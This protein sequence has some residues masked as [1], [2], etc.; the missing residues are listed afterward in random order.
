[1]I[2]PGGLGIDTT[3]TLTPISSQ[4]PATPFPIGWT[5]IKAVDI[6]APGDFDPP[7]EITLIDDKRSAVNQQAVVA[8]FDATAMA[9]IAVAA[10]D[11]PPSGEVNVQGI[12]E[13]GQYALL[14]P[15]GGDGAPVAPIPGEPLTSGSELSLPAEAQAVGVVI[16]SVG[17]SDDPTP[18]KA[19]V[20]ITAPAPMR[21]GT[22]LNGDFMEVYLMRNGEVLQPLESSQDLVAYRTPADASGEKLVAAFPIAP[23]RVFSLA[24]L[25]Q[26]TISV[27]LGATA[28]KSKSLVGG[29]GGGVEAGDGSRVI[30]PAGALQNDV[31]VALKRID[32]ASQGI[33]LTPGF[34]TVGA[35]E[36]DLSG[37]TSTAPLT[38]S[39]G[40][41]AAL[42]P[43]GATVVVAEVTEVA[44]R[45]RLVLVALAE[46]DGDALTSVHTLADTALPGIDHG[47]RYVFLSYQGDLALVTG[48][49]RD[50]SGRRDGHVLELDGSP[51]VSITNAAGG[52][53]LASPPGTFTLTATGATIADKV[54]VTGQTDVPL[55]EI[56]IT[57]TPPRITSIVVRAPKV[58][59]NYA[60]PVALLG[61]PRPIIDDDGNGAS[62]GNGDGVIEA[63]ETVELTLFLRNDGTIAVDKS[64]FALSIDSPGGALAVQ[65]GT[66]KID[67]IGPDETVSVGPFVF[68]APAGSDPSVWKY[69]LVRSNTGGIAGITRFTLPLAAEHPDVPVN[70]EIVIA[71][72]EPINRSTLEGN[73]LLTRDGA[74]G[75]VPC[76]MVVGD[77]SQTVTL[78]PLKNLQDDALYLLTLNE[79]IVDSD[80]RPLA[81]APVTERIRTED[82][83]PPAPIDP[84]KVEMSVPD[85]DGY[86]TVTATL[87]SASPEDTV[88]LFNQSTGYTAVATVN[89]DGSFT[90]RLQATVDD[91]ITIFVRDRS[92]NETTLDPGAF[93]DRHPVTGKIRSVVLG[94]KGGDVPS[95]EGFLLSVPAGALTGATEFSLSR[96]TEGFTLPPDIAADANLQAVFLSL[97]R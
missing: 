86:V 74:T 52:F 34:V 63:G 70:S 65:P 80:G 16:P 62:N 90:G 68:T 6:G 18:A 7:A 81:A 55:S 26:G 78:R 15:D 50:E 42:V 45:Q 88:I 17:R 23:S 27:S 14:V 53:T 85:T 89:S 5:P 32:T 57:A 30:I 25:E 87:G 19:E 76:A 96:A 38:L 20:T 4:G 2:P 29:N 71:F 56:L 21:S 44:G 1:M 47:G 95:A 75:P 58:E 77:D 82:L 43:A 72:S 39:L 94:R 31:P 9:W 61:N 24:E 64:D 54:T 22:V 67:S 69:T 66:I 10:A 40:D 46:I 51:L 3:V 79:A 59:G 28:A 37:A 48:S 92:G 41:G 33:K 91:E 8:R 60:G 12:T 49:A 97:S 84:G 11:V 93:I 36:L 35:L 13:G 83:T 73:I